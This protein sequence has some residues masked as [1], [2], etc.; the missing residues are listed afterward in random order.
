MATNP[1]IENQQRNRHD[2]RTTRKILLV[3]K[4]EEQTLLHL[5]IAQYTVELLL[6][7]V[8]ALPVLTVDDE[9]EALRAGVVVPPEGPDL[10]LSADVPHVELDVLVGHRL[11]VKTNCARESR[12][13]AASP[14]RGPQGMRERTCWDGGDRLVQLELVEDGLRR[15]AASANASDV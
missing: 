9:H 2:K 10:V 14:R 3:R 12:V 4:D 13:S 6:G 1:N 5:P 7:L 11:H 15:G 8:Y